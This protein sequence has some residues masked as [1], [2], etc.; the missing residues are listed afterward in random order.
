[1]EQSSFRVGGFHSSAGEEQVYTAEKAD[2]ERL[3]YAISWAETSNCT[4]GTGLTHNN[5]FG[6]RQ[7]S[8]VPCTLGRSNF[9]IYETPAESFKAFRKIWEEGYGGRYP[10]RKDAE[11]WTNND[12]VDNWLSIVANYY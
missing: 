2:I 11:V 9:C 6:L 12:R 3:A 7:S 1:V 5:C 4:E 10:T 8:I